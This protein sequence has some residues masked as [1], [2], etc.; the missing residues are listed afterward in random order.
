MAKF[1]ATME[2]GNPPQG[3]IKAVVSFKDNC[4]GRWEYVGKLPLI[5]TQEIMM[6]C[7]SEGKRH[8][9]VEGQDEG[10]AAAI[11]ASNK[12]QA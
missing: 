2:K 4:G 10:I 12:E 6:M 11:P 9:L 5:L 1:R 8:C 3:T 7:A